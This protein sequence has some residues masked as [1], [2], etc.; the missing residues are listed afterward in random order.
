MEANFGQFIPVPDYKTFKGFVFCYTNINYSPLGKIISLLYKPSPVY[1]QFKLDDGSVTDEF[2]LIP[3]NARN[4][5][6]VSEYA[7]NID[8]LS[9]NFQDK[10]ISV[11]GG[12][13]MPNYGGIKVLKPINTCLFF[14]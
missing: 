3:D 2:R 13:E 10:G 8:D 9:H 4:G 7:E 1:I 14:S 11:N 5:L 6:F 12:L